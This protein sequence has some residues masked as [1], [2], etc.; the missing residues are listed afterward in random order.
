MP[1]R[2]VQDDLIVF[3]NIIQGE[4]VRDGCLTERE[5]MIELREQLIYLLQ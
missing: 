2:K 5:K 3:H 4:A 1:V